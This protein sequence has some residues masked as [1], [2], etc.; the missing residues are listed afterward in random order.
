MTYESSA[1]KKEFR[2]YPWS[3]SNWQCSFCNAQLKIRFCT[4]EEL[5]EYDI[6]GEDTVIQRDFHHNIFL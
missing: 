5:R 1:L 4:F 6:N 3:S 2:Q